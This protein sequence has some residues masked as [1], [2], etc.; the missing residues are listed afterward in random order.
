MTTAGASVCLRTGPDRLD[1]LSYCRRRACFRRGSDIARGSRHVRLVAVR[2]RAS[3]E[4]KR[5]GLLQH[6]RLRPG[7]ERGRVVGEDRLPNRGY[8]SRHDALR[9]HQHDLSV[10]RRSWTKLGLPDGLPLPSDGVLMPIIETA[11][12]LALLVAHHG[13]C[14]PR[15]VVLKALW[16][17]Y[18]EAPIGRGLAMTGSVVEIA[19][20]PKGSWS[21]FFTSAEGVSCLVLSGEA[22][23]AVEP[24]PPADPEVRQ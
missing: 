23:Q 4:R 11:L 12:A 17:N 9:H 15:D 10:L 13:T 5:D 14:A 6:H 19:A 1:E 16:D 21:M 2:K 8:D 18:G 24:K 3:P 22:W 20:S 7:A